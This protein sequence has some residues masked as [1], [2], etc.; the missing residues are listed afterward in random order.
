VGVL[1]PA[2]GGARARALA[3][4]CASGIRQLQLA[5]AMYAQDYGR[6]MPAAVDLFPP[7]NVRARENTHR[8]FGTRENP[9]GPFSPE[10]GPITAYLDGAGS[11]AGVRRCPAFV[12]TLDELERTGAG[13]EGGCGG[14]GYNA[15]F[16]G[17][18]RERPANGAG[19]AWVLATRVEGGRTVRVGDD[20]G[21]PPH[22]FRRPA[23][24]VAFADSA[25]AATTLIEYSFVEPPEWPDFPGFRPDP[26][27]H[28]RHAG[29]ASVCWLDG[30]VSAER[31]T[32]SAS[33]GVY[34]TD[35]EA[36][37]LGWFGDERGAN[38]LF[39]YR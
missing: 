2:L 7:A 18:T 13:F 5:K 9:S 21:A 25:L 37:E 22:W 39:E 23:R 30:H 24:T 4:G 27:I 10:G 34:P 28:F 32:F 38:E 3:A 16:V 17:S 15:A 19:D 20:A 12:H 33:S 8:W 31:R 26:S 29:R 11:S 1:L 14:Y 36:V 35:P 6:Y